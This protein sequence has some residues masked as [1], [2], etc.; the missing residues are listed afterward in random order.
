MNGLRGHD[1]A[2]DRCIYDRF[3]RNSTLPPTDCIHSGR[4][5]PNGLES[6]LTLRSDSVLVLSYW[7]HALPIFDPLL[8]T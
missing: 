1:R 6:G 3:T 4:R 5:R 2:R 7:L 8:G